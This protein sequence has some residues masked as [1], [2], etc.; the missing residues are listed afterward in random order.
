MVASLAPSG[1]TCN[2]DIDK[3]IE[4]HDK[5]RSLGVMLLWDASVRRVPDARCH[6]YLVNKR[7]VRRDSMVGIRPR[8]PRNSTTIEIEDRSKTTAP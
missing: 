2:L 8:F 6:G 1:E 3:N 7:L 4:I 5:L